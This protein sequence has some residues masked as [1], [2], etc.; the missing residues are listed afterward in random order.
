MTIIDVHTHIWSRETV[1]EKFW[2]ALAQIIAGILKIKPSEVMDSPMMKVSVDGRGDLLVEQMIE[3]GIEKAVTF[4]VDWGLLLG[5]AKVPIDD[6]NKIVSETAKNY[7]DK[8]IPFYTIDP[9]RK[10]AVEKFERAITRDG[11]KGLKIHPTTGYLV[12]GEDAYKLFRKAVE[13]D[14]PVL[15]HMGYLAGLLGGLSQPHYFDQVTFDFPDLRLC[16]AHMNQGNIAELIT[17]LDARANLYV[18]ISAHGQIALY[19][20]P[21]EFHVQLRKVLNHAE[22]RVMFGSDWPATTNAMSLQKF[23][24]TLKDLPSNERTTQILRNLGYKKFKNSEIKKILGKN[25]E[26]F[27]RI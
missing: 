9:R 20:H 10:G 23:V 24:Q 15:S 12:T 11:M 16:V 25:A 17:L 18:D 4:G 2:A 27:L 6:Y 3:A 26:K 1:P 14:V 21:N 13:L 22:D 19:R 5:E 8:L 7:P